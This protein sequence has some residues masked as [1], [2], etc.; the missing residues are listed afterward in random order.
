MNKIWLFGIL[1]C[2]TLKISAWDTRGHRIIAQVAKSS[3]DKT[4]IELVDY[5]LQGMSWDDAATWMD[6]VRTNP[7]NDFMKP[8]HFVN[9]ARDNT[10]VKT[11]DPNVINQLELCLNM[12]KQKAH[13]SLAIVNQQLRILFHLV[14]DIHQPLHCGNTEDNGGNMT[15]VKFQGKASTLHKLWD[16]QLMD[17]KTIDIWSCSKMLLGMP[18]KERTAI[19]QIDVLAWAN[20]SRALLPKVYDFRNGTID[21]AYADASA[22]IITQQLTRAG[23]RLASILN[24]N[25]RR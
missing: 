5:Y 17:A 22:P 23:L 10:Y 15:Q 12:L 18:Q 8:W 13:L 2:I 6:T 3:L 20:E 4:V 16:S 19:Q 9:I 25:F 24:S 21:Q 1:L 14:G 11:K 7:K